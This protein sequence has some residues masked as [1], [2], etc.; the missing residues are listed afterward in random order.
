MIN[1]TKR[2]FYVIIERDEDGYFLHLQNSLTVPQM[3]RIKAPSTELKRRSQ[4][5][6]IKMDNGKRSSRRY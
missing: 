4:T 3:G 1:P 2:E 6:N 5:V